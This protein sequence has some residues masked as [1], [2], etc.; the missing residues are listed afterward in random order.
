M[1]D[2]TARRV[3]AG[4]G[5]ERVEWLD[6]IRALAAGFVVV[7]HVWL[8]TVGGYPGNNGPWFSD[9]MVY[10]HLAVSVFIVVSGFSLTMS[11]LRHGLRLPEGATGFIRRRFWRIVPPY[12][13]A[14]AL[15]VVLVSTGLV[16]TPNGGTVG[17][18]DVAVHAALLQDA[19][20]TTPPNG[21]FWSI[22]VEW[23]IYF[24]FPLVLLLARRWGIALVLLG[25]GAL[26]VAQHLLAGFLPAVAWLDRFSPAYF[27]LF[28]AGSASAC[29]SLRTSSSRWALAV[30]AVLGAAV[31]AASTLSGT[32]WMVSEYFWV[33]LAVGGAT[34]GLFVGMARGGLPWVSR[35]LASR[36]LAFVGQWAFSLY[37]VHAP[38]LD[39][40][41]S[42]ALAPVGISGAAAF[43][44]LLLLGGTAALAS[45]Y[46]FFLVFERPFLRI[47]SLAGLVEF[48]IRPF[49]RFRPKRVFRRRLT[50]LPRG[51]KNP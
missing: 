48:L 1:Q 42:R 32:R 12:W 5:I 9:W 40:I 35:I 37:L 29:L 31:V 25:S 47:R 43:W 26:V 13:A 49:S 14:L 2:L 21:V 46:L 39:L 16:G 4:A 36:P 19:V 22:A 27:V 33:D 44:P 8:M 10:G 7:H 23:H 17:I 51:R 38:V 45:A 3:H 34:A 41:R 15:S 6:G 28:V 30:W 11:P 18:K 24:L 20:G 50:A